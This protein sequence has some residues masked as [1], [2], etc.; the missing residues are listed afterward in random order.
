MWV[1]ALEMV[2]QKPLGIGI[3]VANIPSGQRKT[4]ASHDCKALDPSSYGP[5]GSKTA[6]LR[7]GLASQCVVP[8]RVLTLIE[9][10]RE[11]SLV[12]GPRLS[13]FRHHLPRAFLG[14]TCLCNSCVCKMYGNANKTC[15]KKYM[16]MDGYIYI[17]LNIK[18]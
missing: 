18:L 7:P 9:R 8:K 14:E 1:P 3:Q 5:R 17:Y 2:Q 12:L 4:K 11:E 6:P 16:D 15:I 13:R 10:E